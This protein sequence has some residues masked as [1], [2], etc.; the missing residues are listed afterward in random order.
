MSKRSLRSSSSIKSRTA[1]L[2]LKLEDIVVVTTNPGKIA[3]INQILGTNHK[4]SNSDVPEIQSLNLDEVVKAKAKAAY[5]VIKKPVLV[6]DV[7]LEIE[8]LDDLPGPFVK[9]FVNT[10]GPE[11]T[12]RLIK[13]KNKKV[14]ATDAV[15]IYDGK[16]LLIFKGTAY[17]TLV[18]KA[19]GK[20][21]FGF[22]FVF[23]PNGYKKTYAEMPPELKNKISHRAK[24]LKKLKKYLNS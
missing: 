12:V 18:D 6:T 14:K 23:V 4:A 17:G 20:N 10:L 22:D 8:A 5:K 24:A 16:H 19:R 13:T 3:E 7:S 11:K 15:C 21:G 1:G 9:F 2:K